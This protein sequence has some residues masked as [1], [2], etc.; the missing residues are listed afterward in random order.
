M[1]PEYVTRTP[2]NGSA[3]LLSR[4]S[5]FNHVTSII[6]HCNWRE[7][8]SGDTFWYNFGTVLRQFLE[9]ETSDRCLICIV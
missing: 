4:V 1:H 6:M 7:F 2:T 3:V 5:V 8:W 9:T